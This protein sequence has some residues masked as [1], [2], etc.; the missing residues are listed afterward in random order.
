ME[1]VASFV[2]CTGFS[3]VTDIITK[4]ILSTKLVAT[5]TLAQFAAS[6]CCGFLVLHVLRLHRPQPL[7]RAK[8]RLLLPVMFFQALGFLFAN[9][10]VA[11]VAVSFMHTIKS[12]ESAFTATIAFLVLRQV[13]SAS[14]YASLVPMIVGIYLSSASEVTFSAWGLLAGVAS[15]VCFAC[16]G[17]YSEAIF[18]EKLYDDVNLY[19]IIC[20]GAFVVVLP[21]WLALEAVPSV[22]VVDAALLIK[23]VQ[24]G[25]LHYA[26]NM[27]S[28]MMLSRTSPL[29]HVVLHAVRRML[30]IAFA[31]VYFANPVG[32]H[33]IAGIVLVLV[34]VLWYAFAKAQSARATLKDK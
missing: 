34:G 19:W 14:V 27:F 10:C 13:Y 22:A 32:A 20:T 16:R 26:Y 4:D 28:F 30:V 1:V 15:N 9:Y 21:V 25:A 23:L 11:H 3:I 24:C 6:T 12:S 18:R 31:V 2:L 17:V 8:L 33:N 5:L 7:D 29:T